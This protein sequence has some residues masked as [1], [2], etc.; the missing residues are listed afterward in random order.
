MFWPE[1]LL[2]DSERFLEERF[3]FGV[4]TYH[5][6]QHAQVIKADR[7]IRMFWPKNLL[8]NPEYFLKERFGF[9]VLAHDVVQ[10][11]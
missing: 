2:E 8:P 3:C 5:L 6:V 4:L 7:R 9:G 10:R 1:N 11:R